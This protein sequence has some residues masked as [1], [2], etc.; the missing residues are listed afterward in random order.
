VIP[1][2]RLHSCD[3]HKLICFVARPCYLAHC[4][5]NTATDTWVATSDVTFS[6]GQRDRHPL[7]T[8]NAKTMA[9]S[10]IHADLPAWTPESDF[11]YV[12][13][14]TGVHCALPAK[15]VACL[16]LRLNANCLVTDHDRVHTFRISGYAWCFTPSAA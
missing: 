7:V 10:K 16:Q 1:Q 6:P 8:Y 4:V 15:R 3:L 12:V 11:A 5:Y 9:V 13:L 2:N 14:G